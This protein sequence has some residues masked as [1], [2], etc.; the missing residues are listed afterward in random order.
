MSSTSSRAFELTIEHV[1]TSTTH[2]AFKA[3][4]ESKLGSIHAQ[5]SI[6]DEFEFGKDSVNRKVCIRFKDETG[7]TLN[8]L[9][10]NK[11]S[12]IKYNFY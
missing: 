1:P 8:N 9:K 3:A 10:L 4:I 7:K 6:I 11:I 12:L 2:Q 5:F